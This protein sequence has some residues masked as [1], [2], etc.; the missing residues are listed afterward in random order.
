MLSPL[1]CSGADALTPRLVFVGFAQRFVVIPPALGVA[2][3]T[4]LLVSFAVR[5]VP[6]DLELG[7][8]QGDEH[9]IPLAGR[10]AAE[11]A[12]LARMR[13]AGRVL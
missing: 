7:A 4:A 13:L 9:M 1:P 11:R 8:V 3:A 5:T 12:A 6:L 10:D 2:L